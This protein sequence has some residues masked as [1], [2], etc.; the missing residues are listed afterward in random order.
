MLFQPALI[1]KTGK[2]FQLRKE[3]SSCRSLDVPATGTRQSS[4]SSSPRSI[5]SKKSVWISSCGVRQLAFST[6]KWHK[7]LTAPLPP[8][9]GEKWFSWKPCLKKSHFA[10]YNLHLSRDREGDFLTSPRCLAR[11]A[12]AALVSDG[13]VDR[14]PRREE[15]WL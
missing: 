10:L 11:S 9:R 1:I 2:I 6:V 14:A 3:H 12:L 8:P 7:G 13:T 5:L 4:Q 15:I